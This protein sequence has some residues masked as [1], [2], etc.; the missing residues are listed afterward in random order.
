MIKSVHVV[1]DM[2][3]SAE[4]DTD[5]TCQQDEKMIE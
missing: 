3:G 5:A 2:P 4:S 1:P